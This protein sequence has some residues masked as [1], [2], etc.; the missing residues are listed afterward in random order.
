MLRRVSVNG[1][2]SIPENDDAPPQDRQS[3]VAAQEEVKDSHS[4]DVETGC[5]RGMDPPERD[6]EEKVEEE[7]VQYTHVSVPQP[8][9]NFDNVDMLKVTQSNKE[10]DDKKPKKDEKKTK[11]RLFGGKANKGD[12]D[13]DNDVKELEP[14]TTTKELAMEKGESRCHTISCAICLMDY[15]P[16][17]RISW[18]SN[19]ECTHVFHED[20]VV[21]WL[22]SLG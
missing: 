21:N 7:D 3:T 12:E 14:D 10:E 8:A 22:V 20:C 15:E 2:L 9:H 5:V 4:D 17:E 1:S 6:D 16:S 18:S 19:P 11:I 13:A